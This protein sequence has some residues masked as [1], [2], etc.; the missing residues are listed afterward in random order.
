ME[1]ESRKTRDR[2]RTSDLLRDIADQPDHGTIS[3]GRFVELLGDR[4]FALCILI[5][6]LPNSLPV[7]GI[8]GFSTITGVPILLIALQIVFGRKA[9]WLPPKIAAKSF[10]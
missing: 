2:K 5:F 4:S 3:V 10:T 6:S 1:S 7:P 9:I 8:P